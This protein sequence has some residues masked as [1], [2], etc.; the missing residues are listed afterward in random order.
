MFVLDAFSGSQF[1]IVV[2]MLLSG[3]IVRYLDWQSVFYITGG[4][5]CLWF[6]F[7]AVLVFDSPAAHPRISKVG[8][9]FLLAFAC[10]H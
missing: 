3:L 4:M 2:G 7:W 10:T 6:V 1:G 5:G 8:T 9:R